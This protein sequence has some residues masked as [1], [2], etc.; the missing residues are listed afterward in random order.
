M[1]VLQNGVSPA[2]AVL[3]VIRGMTYRCSFRWFANEA[4]TVA[5]NLTGVTV[6]L[7]V[8]GL[9]TLTVGNGLTVNAAAGTCA[10][11]IPPALS[12]GVQLDQAH[13][14]ITFEENSEEVAPPVAGTMTL[15]NP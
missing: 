5:L 10:V 6:T 13:F 9:F 8:V 14:Y 1:T 4:E 12:R 11:K 3:E 2:P 7:T 15:T